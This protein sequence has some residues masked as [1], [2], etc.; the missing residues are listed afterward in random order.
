MNRWRDLARSLPFPQVIATD[1]DGTLLQADGGV[2]ARTAAAV[3][4]YVERGGAF[5]MATARPP[6]WLDPVLHL[7][8][9]DGGVIIATNGGFVVDADSGAVVEAH[10]FEGAAVIGL[11]AALRRAFPAMN[12]A[13]ET[14][15]GIVRGPGFAVD[16]R[17]PSGVSADDLAAW[18]GGHPGVTVGKLLARCPGLDPRELH[19][20]AEAIVGDDGHL[21]YSG[22]PGLLE[23]TAP[24]VTKAGALSRWCAERGLSPAAMWSFGAMPNDVPMLRLAATSYA[25]ANAHPDVVAVASAVCP[26]HT[27]DG[28]AQVI[29]AAVAAY[30]G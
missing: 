29:E 2:S 12:F 14:D 5:V 22:A 18:L 20:R 8:H 30:G 16:P 25:V 19:V 1:L 21:A 9:D 24:G 4:A 27:D 10:G 28:V 7:V 3:S 26:H 13:V 6:R 17:D 11:L 15:E 23:V